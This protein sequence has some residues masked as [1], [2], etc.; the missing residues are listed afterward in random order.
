MLNIQSHYT[1]ALMNSFYGYFFEP[2]IG[3][4]SFIPLKQPNSLAMTL[5]FMVPAMQDVLLVLYNAYY[6][7][8]EQYANHEGTADLRLLMPPPRR[9]GAI[10]GLQTPNRPPE[11]FNGQ[12]PSR[13]RMVEHLG[14]KDEEGDEDY[15]ED[16]GD[17]DDYS[18]E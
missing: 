16:D 7:E 14:D 11:A 6:G 9:C 1:L 12:Q 18:V 2:R 4:R 5:S 17:E 13:G 10:G 3:E 8:L 15:S